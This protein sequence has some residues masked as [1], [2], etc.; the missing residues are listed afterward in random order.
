MKA[1]REPRSHHFAG[2]ARVV[3]FLA[4][5]HSTTPGVCQQGMHRVISAS[6]GRAKQ[7]GSVGMPSF[8]AFVHLR[9]P[10][11][12]FPQFLEGPTRCSQLGI[13]CTSQ[14]RKKGLP[15]TQLPRSC[16]WRITR[17]LSPSKARRKWLS[18]C[19]Q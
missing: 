16:S 3:Q 17:L 11:G 15:I 1:P 12:N 13:P 10:T 4:S 18:K 7:K 6:G 9:P 14:D 19:C 8:T 2:D 5:H